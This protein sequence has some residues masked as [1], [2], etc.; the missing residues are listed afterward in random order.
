MN[1]EIAATARWGKAEID[2]RAARLAD[3][4]TG[5]WPGPLGRGDDPDAARDWTQLHRALAL[6]PA[7]SWTTYGDLA[8]LIGSHPVAVGGHLATRP[9]PNAWRVLTADGHPSKQFR[10]LDDT[11]SGSQRDTLQAEGIPFDDWGRAGPQHRLTAVDL[12]RLMGLDV[13]DELPSPPSGEPVSERHQGFLAQLD[14]SPDRR[15]TDGVRTLLDRW[16]GLGGSLSFGAAEETSCFTT[17]HGPAWSS[18]GIWPLVLYPRSGAVEVVFQHLA[19]RPPFDDPALRRELRDQLN[20]INGIDLPESKLALRPSF[21]LT[22]LAASSAVDQISRV[23]EWFVSTCLT[24]QD[25]TI[26]PGE[27]NEP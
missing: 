14:D 21:P 10:W 9:A 15:T 4:I 8:E 20:T 23:L 13:A 22:V 26:T 18:R 5:L 7:G 25:D 24:P 3:R 27:P 16:R 12:A 6:M 2:A 17:L 11:H 19:R 1:R